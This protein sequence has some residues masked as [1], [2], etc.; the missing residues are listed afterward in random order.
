[1]SEVDH[2]HPHTPPYSSLFDSTERNEPTDQVIFYKNAAPSGEEA[3]SELSDIYGRVSRKFW[4]GLVS[5]CFDTSTSRSSTLATTVA[6][7]SVLVPYHIT[8]SPQSI[9]THTGKVLLDNG[10]TYKKGHFFNVRGYKLITQEWIPLKSRGIIIILHGYGDHGQTTLAEDALKF[11]KE[12]WSTFIFDQQGHGLSEGLPCYVRDFDDLVDDSIHFISDIIARFPDQKRFIHSCSMGGAVGLLLSMKRPDIFNG[13]LVL[14]APLIKLDDGMKPSPIVIYMLTWLCMA[15]PTLPVVPGENVLDRNIKDP[16]KRE[17][18]ANDPLT[19]KGRTR[20]GT[21]LAILNVTSKL[22]TMLNQVTVPIL[23]MHGA[24]DRVSSPIVSEQL[25][26]EASSK[27][28]TLKIY[29]GMWHGLMSEPDSH[30][31]EIISESEDSQ[32]GRQIGFSPN[33]RHQFQSRQGDIKYAPISQTD[34]SHPTYGS[35]IK[36]SLTAPGWQSRLLAEFD[37]PYFSTLLEFLEGEK[38]TGIIICPPV[39]SIFRSYNLTDFS[40]VKVVILGQDPYYGTDQANG[41]SFSVGSTSKGLPASLANIYTELTTDLGVCKGVTHGNLERWATQG[42]LLLNTCLTVRKGAPESHSDRGWETF[43][44][45]TISLLSAGRQGVIFFLWG[46]HAQQ[47]ASL[48]DKERHTILT[49]SHPSPFSVSKGFYGCRHF[50]LANST[51]LSGINSRRAFNGSS[52]SFNP[53]SLHDHD[54]DS[55]GEENRRPSID[56]SKGSLSRSGQQTTV[57]KS[58]WTIRSLKENPEIADIIDRL[59]PINRAISLGQHYAY[60]ETLLKDDPLLGADTMMQLIMQHLQ[61]EGLISSRKTLEEESGIKYPDYAFNESRLVTMVRTALKDSERIFSLTLDERQKDSQ[62]LLEEHLAFLGLLYEEPIEVED[63]NVYDEPEHSNIIFV[64]EKEQAAMQTAGGSGP[65]PMSL[66]TSAGQA[67]SPSL[68]L[69]SSMSSL[70]L[71]KGGLDEPIKAIKAASLNKLVIL[72]TPEKNHDLEYAKT[73]LMTYQSFTTSEQLLQKLIQRYHVPQKQGQSEEE[74]KKIAIPIQLRVV[75][76]LKTWIKDNFSDFNDRLIQTIKAFCENLRHEGNNSHSSRIMTTLNSKIKG[77]GG[78]DDE[79]DKKSKT[80]FAMSAPEPKVPKNIWSQSLN[81]FD[82]DEEEIARQ[83]TLIDF[84][85]FSNIKSSE[86]LNQAWSKPKLRHRSPHVMA[87]INRFNEISSW[88]ASMILSF[89]KVK[90]RARIMS[91]FIKICENLMKPLNNFNTSMAI[92]SGLN[93]ASVHRLKFTKEEMPKHT[94]QTY[95][96]LQAQLHSNQ[97]YK[98]YRE[99]LQKSNPPCLPYLGVCLTDLTFIEDGNPDMIQGFINFNEKNKELSLQ[100]KLSANKEYLAKRYQKALVLYTRALEFGGLPKSNSQTDSHHKSYIINAKQDASLSCKLRPSW[101]KS[102]MRLA[103]DMKSECN[104]LLGRQ[105][106]SEVDDPAYTPGTMEDVNAKVKEMVKGM[107]MEESRRD[108]KDLSRQEIE[109]FQ[110]CQLGHRHQLGDKNTRPD[111]AKAASYFRKAAS[112]GSP[113]GLYNLA[114]MFADGN[115]VA[116]DI[117]QSMELLRQ[118]ASKPPFLSNGRMRSLGVGEAMHAIGLRYYN[119]VVVDKDL[120][121]ASVWFEK[122]AKLEMPNSLNNLGLMLCSGED[123]IK[124][125]WD[126]GLQLIEKAALL[127]DVNAMINYAVFNTSQQGLRFLEEAAKLGSIQAQIKLPAYKEQLKDL[128]S[129]PAIEELLKQFDKVKDTLHPP[130]PM[131]TRNSEVI[132]DYEMLSKISK[133]KGDKTM[134]TLMVQALDFYHDFIYKM[135]EQNTIDLELMSRGIELAEYLL[136][137]PV[138]VRSELQDHA[139]EICEK[140]PSNRA[141]RVCYGY[142]LQDL[143]L[144]IQ[145]TLQSVNLFPKDPY[146]RYH[147]GALYAFTQNYEKLL[148]YINGLLVSYP[149]N[150]HYLYHKALGARLGQRSS[151][152]TVKAYQ[153]YLAVAPADER[154]VPESY[155]AMASLYFTDPDK[156]I[157]QSY[158]QKEKDPSCRIQKDNSNNTSFINF[159]T[160][161][162][163][164]NTSFINFNT[165]ITNFNTSIINN[166]QKEKE[167]EEE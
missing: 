97:A 1:M 27:D 29:E 63:V 122:A 163:N 166:K 53:G 18:H 94:Q 144:A 100:L 82:V 34:A 127:G 51:N 136:Q 58:L 88:T 108:I 12:G 138:D 50:S 140:T 75:N 86:L 152:E 90:D 134:A 43:T 25:Y 45:T 31:N 156:T 9:I 8:M 26:Q 71:Q 60:E 62:Q 154:K 133:A 15:L 107:T 59:K 14:L 130:K 41:L 93:A 128:K 47:K 145:F 105:E 3:D 141:A 137:L 99:L 13:G 159:N 146:F 24:D 74:W 85:V 164:F 73:F 28:K 81:I 101:A 23:I 77:G 123:G 78:D 38:E 33:K 167:K 111:P 91:K 119:G 149:N 52:S 142:L 80:I 10:I 132:Y 21:G 46:K 40:D 64:E 92:L 22:Q 118:A 65:S 153:D 19:Y 139:R 37:K 36:T 157:V 158:Y 103:N 56:S 147:L 39:S 76:I 89:D 117:R 5:E 102:Y 84:E 115:G 66:S 69:S 17:A 96:D 30:I 151:Y 112:T 155:Y 150:Y 106:R 11:S 49:A 148:Y 4:T 98:V 44:D 57:D 83:L 95:A 7:L 54:S 121:L 61:Y 114:L 116:K 67:S 6:V 42:V 87:L 129:T 109:W 120:T 113:E 20:L 162:I 79:D 55:T 32:T 110:T 72:L 16:K 68:T 161:F 126:R 135:V 70:S 165:S 35:M 48:I 143:P 131:P 2:L 125:D 104:L 124:R 160:S